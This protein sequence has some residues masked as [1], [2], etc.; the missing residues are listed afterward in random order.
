MRTVTDVKNLKSH[1]AKLVPWNQEG[2]LKSGR[3]VQLGN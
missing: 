1:V 3:V 2:I